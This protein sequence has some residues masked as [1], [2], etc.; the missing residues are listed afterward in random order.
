MM[1]AE[2]TLHLIPQQF[3]SVPLDLKGRRMRKAPCLG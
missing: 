1:L 2:H 3:K